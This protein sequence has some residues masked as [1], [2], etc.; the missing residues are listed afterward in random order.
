MHYAYPPRKS[1]NPP[2]YLPRTS[3]ISRIRKSHLRSIVL[4]VLAIVGLIWLFSGSSKHR[5]HHTISG[6]PPVVLVTVLDDTNSNSVYIKNI[7]ENRIQY[8]EKHGYGTLL[9][10][11]SDYDLN[12]SPTSWAK[13]V[14]MRHAIT[15]YPDCKYLWYL[16]QDAFIMNPSLK[17][18]DYVMG[19]SK[20]E[21][22]ML[23]DLPVV[24]PD[25]IIKTFSHL[26][27]DDVEFVLTQDKEGLATGSF[28][29]KNGE[30]AKFFLD[31]WFDP[32]YRSYNFQKAETHALEH[33]VQW[34]P[35]ILSKLAIIPQRMINAYSSHDHGDQYK[36]GDI[37]VLF[38]RCTNA[39]EKSCSK[40]SERFSQQWRT[41]FSRA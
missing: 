15:K 39:G 8:A 18:E 37:A 4:F 40:E 20:L 14:A 22:A 16:E 35:T 31:T 3:R 36:D 17:V 33:I 23:K 9:V 32:L 34:H 29:I 24:P 30:W 21:S 10:K 6:K 25:S 2:P 1:S 28:V 5:S 19:T 38:A 27:S 41:S 7:K 26:K 12:G 13:V 11:A